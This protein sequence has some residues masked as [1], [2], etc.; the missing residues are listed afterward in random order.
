MATPRSRP[1]TGLRG[2]QDADPAL[3]KAP[4]PSV[5]AALAAAAL[6][7]WLNP[8][9]EA[10]RVAIKEAVAERSPVAGLLGLGAITAFTS[11]HHPLGVAS[12]TTVDG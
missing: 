10:H 9:P 4:L 11:T 3:L 2:R 7:F 6:A 8:S 5:M 12:H 1:A